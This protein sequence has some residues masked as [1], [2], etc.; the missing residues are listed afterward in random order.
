MF[1]SSTCLA[2]FFVVIDMNRSF[3]ASWISR[4]TGLVLGVMLIAGCGL[5]GA[6]DAG[7][8]DPLPGEV[9]PTSRGVYTDDM[10]LHVRRE[11]QGES[12]GQ[13]AL[14]DHP[15]A[16]RV[17]RIRTWLRD[18][19]VRPEDGGEPL[20]LVPSEQLPELSAILAQALREARPD[21]D[22]V[23]HVFRTAGS[24]F[25]SERRVT[26]ARVFYR[27]GALNLIF[28]DLDDFYSER[29][30][31]NLQPLRSGKR[32]SESELSG[33]VVDSPRVAFVNNR[34]DWIRLDAAAVSAPTRARPSPKI[35]EPMSVS[36]P[37]PTTRDP[38]W[39]QLEE[40]LLILDGLRQKGLISQDDYETK[41][42]E[43]LEVL[44]L[45]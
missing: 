21:E 15:V 6:R 44:D 42:Q 11:P 41:K 2:K 23:F 1:E 7:R 40:R 28:G 45:K 20:T 17:K 18:L 36:T 8:E 19:E 9:T 34:D 32:G 22:V 37:A 33:R 39:T 26:T 13:V 30:D 12:G 29:I 43:L 5:L 3:A 25:G 31:R 14:N 10:Y 4:I 35:A 24:W 27:N 38:R 16:L